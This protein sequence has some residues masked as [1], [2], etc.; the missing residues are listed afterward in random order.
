[1]FW[2]PGTKNVGWLS[3]EYAFPVAEPSEALLDRIW[4]FCKI[5]VAQMRGIHECEFCPAR[6]TTYIKRG[7]EPLL[8]GSSEFRCSPNT[9]LST[10]PRLS[11]ITMLQFI[12]ILHRTSFSAPFAKNPVLPNRC[13]SISWHVLVLPGTR[14]LLPPKSPK[15]SSLFAKAIRLSGRRCDSRLGPDRRAL[16][17]PRLPGAKEP[18][19]IAAAIPSCGAIRTRGRPGRRS[20]ARGRRRRWRRRSSA[21]RRWSCRARRRRSHRRDRSPGA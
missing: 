10:L 20:R 8:L 16:R 14:R 15:D 11:S 19:G 13:T 18:T 1:M 7:G 17:Q 12:T 21:G 9:G 3:S 4:S 6:Q 5:S 2:V